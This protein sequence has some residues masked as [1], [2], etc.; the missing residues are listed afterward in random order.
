MAPP[1]SS[2]NE[3]RASL[4]GRLP[5]RVATA[6]EQ[7]EADRKYTVTHR[8]R[9]RPRAGEQEEEELQVWKQED[10]RPHPH[11]KWRQASADAVGPADGEGWSRGAVSTS[12]HVLHA[13][14]VNL[15][16]IIHR[17]DTEQQVESHAHPSHP[18]T[19]VHHPPYCREK[20]STINK[21]LTLQKKKK[22]NHNQC[23]PARPI[24]DRITGLF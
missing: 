22:L 6:A 15:K 1:L 9:V 19:E 14:A 3:R 16:D 2:V 21:P 5:G 24:K 20:Q 18:L 10:Q 13:N 17:H 23:D 12:L 8:A 7:G 4:I 11:R